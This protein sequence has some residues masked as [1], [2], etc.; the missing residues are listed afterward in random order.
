[1]IESSA[2]GEGVKGFRYG[3]LVVLSSSGGERSSIRDVLSPETP[4]QK[5]KR[6]GV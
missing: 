4:R 2:V 5:Q 1:M 6:Y 3:G